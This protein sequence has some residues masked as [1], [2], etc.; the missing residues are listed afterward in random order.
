VKATARDFIARC[1]RNGLAFA[2][3]AFSY[4]PGDPD[5]SVLMRPGSKKSSAAQS[6]ILQIIED[7][8]HNGVTAEEL[9]K[10]KKI[11]LSQELASLRPCAPGD[12]SRTNWFSLAI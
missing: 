1:A 8:R 4:T 7:I 5:F 2:I 11:A 3:S 6:L 10:V 12:R 9:A